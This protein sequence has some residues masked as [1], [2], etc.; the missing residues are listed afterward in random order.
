[1]K[2]ILCPNYRASCWSLLATAIFT[3]SIASAGYCAWQN[4][5]DEPPFANFLAADKGYGVTTDLTL[6]NDIELRDNLKLLSESG[7]TWIRQPVPWSELE[8]APGQFNWLPFDRIVGQASS[9]SVPLKLVAVL[10]TSP[11]WARPADTPPTTPPN[12]LNDF[13]NFARQFATRYGQQIDYYQIWHEPNLSANWGNGYVDPLAYADLLREAAVNI[14]AVDPTAFIICAGLAPTLENGPLN[15]NEMAYLDKLYQAQAEQW[16]DIMSAQIYGFA[17]EPEHPADA[18]VLSFNRTELLRRVMV[19]HGDSARPIWATAFG[20][21]VFPD[22]WTGRKSLWKQAIP[23]VQTQRTAN[24]I[25]HVR[26]QWS[27]LGPMF[28]IRW[29][30]ADLAK[31]DPAFGFAIKEHPSV[32]GAFQ[33]MSS[34]VQVATIGRYPAHHVSGRYSEGWRFGKDLADIPFPTADKSPSTLNIAFQGTRFDLTIQRGFYRGYLWVTLDQ[35][36]NSLEPAPANGLPQ[37]DDGRSYVVLYDP[38]QQGETLTLARNLSPGFHEVKITADGGWGK[39]AIGGWTVYNEVDTRPYQVGLVVAGL[40]AVGSGA[41]MFWWLFYTIA[42]LLRSIWAWSESVIAIY[43]TLGNNWQIGLTV[44]LAVG[45]YLSPNGYALALLPLLG[46]TILLRPDVGLILI[47]ASLSFFQAPVDLPIKDF[48][49]VEFSLGLTVIG[50]WGRGLILLGRHR[51]AHEDWAQG[52]DLSQPIFPTNDKTCRT[53]ILP[54]VFGQARCLSY[55]FAALALVGLALLATLNAQIFGVSMFEWRVIV[56]ESV[57]FYFLVR[58]RLDFSPQT[59]AVLE[60]A[61]VWA[62][63][64][65]NGWLGGAVAQ[66]MIAL[67]FYFFTDKSITAEGVRRAMGLAYGSPNN[68]ALFLE[69]VWPLLVVLTL[70]K[71]D[72]FL[73]PVRFWQMTF[74]PVSLVIVTI[75]IFLTFSKGTLLLGLPLAM[76]FMGIAYSL[77]N[78]KASSGNLKASFEI[79]NVKKWLIIAGSL[80]ILVLLPLSQ[81]ARFQGVLD[82]SAGSTTF[83]RVKL[84]RAAWSMFQDHWV[85]GVGLDNFLYQYRT[86][87]ILPSAWQEP[88]LSHP[89]NLILDFGTRLGIGGIILLGIL[90]W[91]FWRTAWRLYKSKIQSPQSKIL[92]LGLM[93]SMTTFLAHGL[94]DNSYFLVDL[95]FTFFLTVGLIQGLTEQELSARQQADGDPQP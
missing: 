65:V 18:R 1:M 11:T 39:W 19:A 28:A 57:L 10:H 13:G 37:D 21:A 41:G 48:S 59:G 36:E 38:L 85:L 73:K 32:L 79:P 50:L 6:Y 17:T 53:G 71:P 23:A 76:L 81:T 66:A 88:N 35:D 42:G 49:P 61:P 46:L 63:R 80:T 25:L 58:L 68:L 5:Y 56:L 95:A 90:Q 94:V 78:L 83:F 87:Y 44:A 26:R 34:T 47:V 77:G 51:Y 22:D 74:Y 31:N 15:L 89:H 7:F 29:D 40:L 62:W 72:R 16:F 14:R 2:T 12:K 55:D 24:A 43:A 20:W 30:T 84:W 93:G 33:T 60:T 75:T 4:W 67:Y 70:F 54:V 8:P 45:L 92:V 69:R 9:L 91:L 82:F 64:L 52:M 3:L 86:R 27:W